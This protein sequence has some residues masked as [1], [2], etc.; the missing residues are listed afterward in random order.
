MTNKTNSPISDSTMG[1]DYLFAS[2]VNDCTGLTPTV[3]HN[4]YE[5]A[6][7]DEIVNYLP[8]VPP[9]IMPGTSPTPVV[10]YLA[11]IGTEAPTEAG[12]GSLMRAEGIHAEVNTLNRYHENLETD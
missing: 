3:A 6:S 4:E 7:Y 1:D 9:P 10:P 12:V 8:P 11:P 5:A 2:S